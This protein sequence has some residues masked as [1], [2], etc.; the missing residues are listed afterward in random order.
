MIFWDSLSVYK[1]IWVVV[2]QEL[3]TFSIRAQSL[4]IFLILSLIAHGNSWTLK[5]DNFSEFQNVI[6]DKNKLFGF[7]FLTKL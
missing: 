5:F 4:R 2:E 3:G 1:Y 6:N 7:A